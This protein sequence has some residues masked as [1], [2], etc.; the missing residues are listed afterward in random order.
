RATILYS[1]VVG[2]ANGFQSHLLIPFQ[3]GSAANHVTQNFHYRPL[4]Q[5]I[6]TP[7]RLR[8]QSSGVFALERAPT[9]H[10]TG[11]FCVSRESRGPKLALP[12]PAGG[13]DIAV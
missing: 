3:E 12:R 9:G 2:H 6:H 1:L 11:Q 5:A 4:A 13:A 8:M 7:D 10:G